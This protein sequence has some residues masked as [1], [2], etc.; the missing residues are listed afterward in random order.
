[1]NLFTLKGTPPKERTFKVLSLIV[2]FF[3]SVSVASAQFP[4]FWEIDSTGDW[5]DT[6][7]RSEGLALAEGLVTPV[8]ETGSYHSVMK[9]FTE[10]VAAQSITFK[11]SPAWLNWE[12]V[13][14]VLP[15]NLSDAPVFLRL[16]PA[17]YWAFGQKIT[18]K[19]GGREAR[20][21]GFDIPLKTT[22]F[23][24]V[25]DGPGAFSGHEGGY[26]AWQSRDMKNWVHHGAVTSKRAKWTTT[27]EYHEGKLYLYYD[28][29]ND[30]NPHVYVDE[31]LFDGKPGRDMGMAFKTP[32][33]GSDCT[34]I[35]AI[36][37]RF[38]LIYEDWSPIDASKHSW[39]SPLAGHAIS[40]DGLS[41]FKVMPP[42]VDLRTQPTGVFKEFPH[43][44]WHSE[45]PDNFP[46]KPCP[47]DIPDHA[48]KAGDIRAFAR[49]EVHEP[50]QDA[51]GDWSAISIGG[52][53]YLF[54]DYHPAGKNKWKD[55][56]VAWFTSDEINHPFT[57]CG[58][59]GSGH[60]DPDIGFAEGRFYLFTQTKNDFISPGPWVERVKA[61]V[62]VDTTNNGRIDYWSDWREVKEHYKPIP[63]F[64]KQVARKSASMDLRALPKGYGFVFEFK[65]TDTTENPFKPQINQVT[66]HFESASNL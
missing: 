2:T 34:V 56:S 58:N 47:T 26:H 12:P 55:M 11:Q 53:Y 62:G 40:E 29:P 38:H 41:D 20:L 3:F 1:M 50:E 57:F 14:R 21:E 6:M 45:D 22:A 48:I 59:I 32:S 63:G 19:G 9:R 7:S 54:G 66:L 30:Q 37:G 44:H 17:N 60:P 35:R 13:S 4:V 39:D 64:T 43:P 8:G 51:F 36:T 18:G 31:D 25:F 42:A 28:F 49:Y 24:N 15:Q 46:G 16:G 33:N 23:E 52:Q 65:V 10:K 27:A 61:R 5:E